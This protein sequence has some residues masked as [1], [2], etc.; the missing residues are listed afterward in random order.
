MYINFT[1]IYIVIKVIILL[2][3]YRVSIF[4]F[5]RMHSYRS[6]Q[7]SFRCDSQ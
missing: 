1:R 7:N 6:M 5:E 4:Y 3:M 2:T